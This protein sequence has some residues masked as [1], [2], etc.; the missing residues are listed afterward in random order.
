MPSV[1]VIAWTRSW[2]RKAL[3]ALL[4]K[5]PNALVADATGLLLTRLLQLSRPEFDLLAE[6]AAY[7]QTRAEVIS[8][9]LPHGWE[10]D[11]ESASHARYCSRFPCKRR[12]TR[13]MSWRNART[14]WI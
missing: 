5:Q 4:Q 14:C 7:C 9:A 10:Q 12:T 8:Y 3:Q 2:A 11:K 6:H 13:P 1:L